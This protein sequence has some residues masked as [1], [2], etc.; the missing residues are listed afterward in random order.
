MRPIG[1][2]TATAQANHEHDSYHPLYVKQTRL[3]IIPRI[4][5]YGDHTGRV[6]ADLVNLESIGRRTFAA[7]S[8]TTR[9]S[10]REAMTAPF[11]NSLP[12]SIS[13]ARIR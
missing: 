8:K 11:P 5:Q 3:P 4:L 2:T 6:Y 7:K 9:L 1:W 10:V 12:L 13:F